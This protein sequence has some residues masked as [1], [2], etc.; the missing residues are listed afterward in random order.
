MIDELLASPNSKEV[1]AWLKEAPPDTR[2]LGEMPTTE[3]SLAMANELYAR[4]ATRVTAVKI[5]RYETGEENTGKLIVSLPKEPSARERVFAWCA[6]CAE[7]RGLD[8]DRDTGQ[9]HLF[10]LLD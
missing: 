7:E 8:A 5:D 6:E 1:L 4:G 2:T 10:V 9:D 3:A